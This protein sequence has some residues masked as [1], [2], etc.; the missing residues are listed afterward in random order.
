MDQ[1]SVHTIYKHLPSQDPLKFTQICIFGL[2]TNH[3]ATSEEA[4]Q[5]SFAEINKSTP[6]CSS[7]NHEKWKSKNVFA[8][9]KFGKNTFS[10]GRAERTLKRGKRR[11]N[12]FQK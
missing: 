9:E 11:R 10:N 7:T 8:L 3:L 6:S 4:R 1:V 2:K 12:C 5:M